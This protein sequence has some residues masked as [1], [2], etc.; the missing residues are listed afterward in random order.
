MS[1]QIIVASDNHEASGRVNLPDWP[2]PTMSDPAGLTSLLQ[3]LL[4][5]DKY[6]ADTAAAALAALVGD[7]SNVMLT[8]EGGVA[9]KALNRTGAA[10]EEGMVVSP[11]VGWDVSPGSTTLSNAVLVAGDSLA[12]TSAGKLYLAVTVPGGAAT[13]SAYSDAARTVKV[14]EGALADNLGG[15]VSLAAVGG[16]GLSFDIDVEA[17]AVAAADATMVRGALC[18]VQEAAAAAADQIGVMYTDGI[19]DGG[20]CWIVVAG[21]CQVQVGAGAEIPWGS[22][23]I[24]H[25]TSSGIVQ[26]QYAADSS[27]QQRLV[28][29]ADGRIEGT[30]TTVGCHLELRG[31]WG[32]PA[33]ASPATGSWYSL[34]SLCV[35]GARAPETDNGGYSV[36][37]R[38]TPRWDMQLGQTLRCTGAR[39][40]AKFG[41]YPR[42]IK[43]KLHDDS[44]ETPLA[45]GSVTVSADGIAEVTW[46]TPVT[47]ADSQYG[48]P[49]TISMYETSDTDGTKAAYEAIGT[50]FYAS[51]FV[52]MMNENLYDLG[53][54]RPTTQGV[55]S[56]PVEAIL[57]V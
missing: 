27:K 53:D 8:P 10:T 41:A 34:P 33:V 16:S 36:G 23:L 26:A 52:Q 43:C 38:F 44:S 46:A 28:G 57:E 3:I 21:R 25:A 47:F 6:T 17:G 9:I 20:D 19:P 39:F 32:V 15:T 22:A 29:W 12:N 2:W 11:F 37:C 18:A 35:S 51:P 4:D 5:R 50:Y 13:V 42:T 56:Y 49:H 55:K 24:T 14:A 54:V 1:K 7:G 40:Y 31:S 30:G 45:S 48:K